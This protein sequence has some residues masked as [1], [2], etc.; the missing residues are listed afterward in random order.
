MK[1]QELITKFKLPGYIA[2]L[3]F[4]DASKKIDSKFKDRNDIISKK[5]KEEL[6]GR[7]SQAQEYLKAQQQVEEVPE[8]QIMADGG[9]YDNNNPYFMTNP[10]EQT[11]AGPENGTFLQ[12]NAGL[13]NN[14]MGGLGIANS[15]AQGDTQGAVMSGAQMAAEKGLLGA[16]A[17]EAMGS[18]TPGL[19]VLGAA[20]GALAL[21]DLSQGKGA[22]RNGVKS[23]L[24][25]AA[26]GAMAGSAFGPIGTVAGGVIGLG[27]GIMGSGNRKKEDAEI[28]RL[29]AKNA[30]AVF[31]DKKYAAWGGNLS[32]NDPE[33]GTLNNEQLTKSLSY[34][35]NNPN[36]N[37]PL[38][39][40]FG[41][42]TNLIKNIQNTIGTN[43]DGIWGP[44][45]KKS[46]IHWQNNNNIVADGKYGPQTFNTAGLTPGGRQFVEPVNKLVPKGTTYSLIPQS[47]ISLPTNTKTPT[48]IP[49]KP[50]FLNKAGDFLKNNIGAESLR[51]APLLTDFLQMN[52]M[53][54]PAHESLTRLS[55]NYQPQYMDEATIQNNINSENRNIINALTNSSGGSD[56][57]LRNSLIAS[58]LNATKA[59]SDAYMKMREYNNNQN[60]AAQQFKLKVDQTNLNQS[61]L[62]NDINAR[63]RDNYATQKSKFIGNISTTLGEIGKEQLFKKY[64]KMMGLGYDWNGKYFINN[65]TGDTKTEAEAASLE[66]NKKAKGGFLSKKS[67]TYINSLNKK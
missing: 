2:G 37:I 27:A 62:E 35:Y 25:G 47:N 45:S 6:L 30:N 42:E 13:A 26:T 60:I 46:L 24:T 66:T 21:N 22:S 44:K 29:N 39:A 11:I 61:F 1:S 36:S 59:K 40:Q 63:N 48:I 52:D 55:N 67:M 31:R 56:A 23:A 65:K 49:N 57:A 15:L 19:G 14:V 53:K 20:Q 10:G 18:I 34:M 33:E 17:Q 3:S 7:L 8:N 58:N 41:N 12:R 16:G 32:I 5:T 28:G 54:G 64:P 9:W 38:N 4:A 50:G 51:Y 43:V